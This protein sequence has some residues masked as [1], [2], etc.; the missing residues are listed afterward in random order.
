MNEF[1]KAFQ[2]IAQSAALVAADDDKSLEI[3]ESATTV[4][5]SVQPGFD[6]LRESATRLEK[7]VQKCRNDI[8]HA[9]DVWTCKLGIIQASKQEIWQQLGELSGCHVRINEL[10][11]RCQNS[12]IDQS[13]DYWDKI[14][15]VR[16]KQKW[17]IDAANKQKKGIGWKE[18]DYCLKDIPL[19]VNLVCREIDQIIKRSL[20]LVYQDLS[21]INLKVITQCFGILDKQT[22]AVWNHHM[23]LNFS[24][25]ANKF[26]QPTVYLPEN[27]QSLRSALS[28]AL[29]N[30]SKYRL[31]DLFW[32]EVV[33]FKKQVSTA[34]DNFINSIFD[35]RL[36]H[37][38]R[39]LV[40]ALRFYNEFLEKQDRYQQETPAQRQAERD[41]IDSQWTEIQRL[42]KGIKVILNSSP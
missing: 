16:V 36:Y 9:E 32:E 22:K 7:V 39:A 34:I 40:K 5:K 1:L 33:N 41:W 6:E 35:D 42:E 13:Q 23:N 3:K 38:S 2:N 4:I 31:G 12:A 26:E 28:P 11:Q 8:D 10:G 21:T 15:D 14:F 37:V 18:K 17:F 19:A 25:I 27:T 24:Q 29:D 30:L 20:D